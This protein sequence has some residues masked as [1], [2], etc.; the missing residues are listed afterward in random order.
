[1]IY[2]KLNP[3]KNFY[4]FYHFFTSSYKPEPVDTLFS[5]M[6]LKNFIQKADIVG[7]DSLF[8]Y[9]YILKKKKLYKNMK[10]VNM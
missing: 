3:Q 5:Y 4:D 10:N 9:F 6:E 8:E 1:M 2:E 7:V